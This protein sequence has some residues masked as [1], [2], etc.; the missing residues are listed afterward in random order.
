MTTNRRI[1]LASRP[2]G[3]PVAANFAL[4]EAPLP[5]IG[6][7]E[8]LVRNLVFAIDPATR[9]MLDERE[10][11][12]PAVAIG[13]L[14]PSM[15]LG[16]VV[17]SRNPAFREGDYARGYVGW[18]EFSVLTPDNITIEKVAVDPALPL[19][20]YMGALGW[21]G[22][23]AYIG[24]KKIGEMGRG[25]TVLTS[26]AAGAVGSVAGQMARLCG[27]RSIGIAGGAAKC[28]LVASLG[29]E[30]LDYKAPGDLGAAIRALCP[31]GVGVYFDNVGGSVLDA[32]LP[33]MADFGRIVV[34]GMVADYNTASDPWPIR[35]L[36]QVLVHRVT[37]RG[38][39]AFEHK[40]LVEEAEERLGHWIASGQM[41]ALENVTTGIENTPQAFIA[42]MSG[43]TTGKTVV[44]L[45]AEV[46][47]LG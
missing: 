22:M 2:H 11:Y 12:M 7:G 36:W 5:E 17:Q 45:S 47:C 18:E 29:M 27:N 30:P 25:D 4:A 40:E 21:S 15:V 33:G 32:V 43:R 31:E 3:L 13:G 23:T 38:F 10:S 24:L 9:G 14:I 35:N 1:V 44:R 20:A 16:Q 46:S 39:L 28:E 37:M 8:V 6:E 41:K 42:L 26:A 19:T 34:C